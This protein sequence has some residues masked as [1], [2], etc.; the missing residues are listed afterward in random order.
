MSQTEN[1]ETKT[2]C[3]SKFAALREKKHRQK[4]EPRRRDSMR[5]ATSTQTGVGSWEKKLK[6]ETRGEKA[7]EERSCRNIRAS[8]L[9]RFTFNQFKMLQ[10][11]PLTD[12]SGY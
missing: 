3:L 9:V 10:R 1:I 4:T 6:T 11:V 8:S 2:M 5:I 7:E 12:R